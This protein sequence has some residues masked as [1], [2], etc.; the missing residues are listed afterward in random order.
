V[1]R[2]AITGFLLL[3]L[4]T[5]LYVWTSSGSSETSGFVSPS[6]SVLIES[7]DGHESILAFSTVI[8]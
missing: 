4:L 8:S 7:T 1:Q 5:L 6:S 3:V 2:L